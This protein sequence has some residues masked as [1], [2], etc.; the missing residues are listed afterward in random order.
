MN[1]CFYLP[2]GGNFTYH[3]TSP[4]EAILPT[5]L[6]PPGRQFY[7]PFYLPWRGNFTYHS[8][9]PGGGGGRGGRSTGSIPFSPPRGGSMAGR[10]SSPGRIRNHCTQS[11]DPSTQMYIQALERMHVRSRTLHKSARTNI[12]LHLSGDV[13]WQTS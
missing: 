11:A 4:G 3:S 7:L 10:I 9:S 5:I 12:C 2:W 6:P 8:T 13:N 1:L